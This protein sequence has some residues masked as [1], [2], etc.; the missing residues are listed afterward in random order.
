M[1]LAHLAGIRLLATGGIGGVHRG[2]NETFDI[3][4]DLVELARTPVCV[5]CS[6]AKSILDIPKTLEVLETQG[7]PVIGYGADEFPAFY[8][9]SSGER[10][11]ARVDTPDQAARLLQTH[12]A[13]QGGGAVLAQ[14]ALSESAFTSEEF[15]M[16]LRLAEA[17]S[18][19]Q[20]VKGKALTPFL[21]ARLAH[22][23]HG[24]TLVV[25]RAL[26]VDNARLAAK[27][28]GALQRISSE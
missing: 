13:L 19:A 8:V 18:R 7:V 27:V 25:N 17:E 28:A 22:Y 20:R 10:L 21:L 24:K 4:A 12:W 14:P 15:E 2:A 11:D 9:R 16:A 1:F 26:V 5:V 6:G 23:T 3:S